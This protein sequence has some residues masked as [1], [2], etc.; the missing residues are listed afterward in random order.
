MRKKI[1]IVVD[2]YKLEPFLKGLEKNDFELLDT[3]PSVGR[4]ILI[5][6]MVPEQRIKELTKLI[7]KLEIDVKRSN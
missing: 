1:G 6:V 7:K 3:T 5:R 4:T 2:P